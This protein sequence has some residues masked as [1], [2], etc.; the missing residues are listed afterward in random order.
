MA[1]LPSAEE[2]PDLDARLE[3]VGCLH[4]PY[5]A[6][7]RARLTHGAPT[8]SQGSHKVGDEFGSVDVHSEGVHGGHYRRSA[9]AADSVDRVE[10]SNEGLGRSRC[11]VRTSNSA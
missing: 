6:R 4:V 10:D 8:A 1:R 9:K 5:A 3:I 7:P 2:E 11:G